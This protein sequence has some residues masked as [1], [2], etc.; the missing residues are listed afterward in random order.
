[1]EWQISTSAPGPPKSQLNTA[2]Q[3]NPP[4]ARHP[5]TVRARLQAVNALGDGEVVERDDRRLDLHVVPVRDDHLR[6][7]RPRPLSAAH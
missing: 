2:R 3:K 5:A 1:M 4:K 6:A 7:A